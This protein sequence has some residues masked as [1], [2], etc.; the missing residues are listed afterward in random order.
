MDLNVFESGGLS[1][2]DIHEIQT[3]MLEQKQKLSAESEVK[4]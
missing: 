1:R 3:A 4:S 2:E